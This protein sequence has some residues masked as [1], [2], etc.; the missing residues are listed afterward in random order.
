MRENEEGIYDVNDPV[1]ESAPKDSYYEEEE[2]TE[3]DQYEDDPVEEEYAD[4]PEDDVEEEAVYRTQEEV[5]DAIKRRLKRYERKVAKELGDLSV[6]EAREWI[7]AGKSVA[8][9]SG[10]TPA[11]I[12][13]KLEESRMQQAQQ[14]G[15]PYT[16]AV[17][18]VK[19]E[20]AEMRSMLEEDRHEKTRRLEEQEARKEFGDLYTKYED[21]IV[22]KAE[23]HGLKLAD[24]AA[25]VLRPKLR[26]LTEQ[27]VRTKQQVQKQR[28]VEDSSGAP[29]T[30]TVDF[31]TA[32]TPRE[33]EAA[34]KM[35]LT[36]EQ[37]YEQKKLLGEIE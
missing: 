25:I 18:P 35:H 26:E 28:K 29:D 33:K 19:Q 4:E 7:E 32:L 9:A 27:K 11:Q 21:S 12:K 16:P 22:D 30:K 31:R 20:L 37:Y 36:L 10:L 17:D 8:E 2:Y 3:E 24:A 15:Q 1:Q 13:M 34:R 6:Q 23:E 5:D 14:T